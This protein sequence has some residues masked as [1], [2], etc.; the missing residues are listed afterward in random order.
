MLRVELEVEGE[1]CTLITLVPV[2]TFTLNLGR[3][4]YVLGWSS[5]HFTA[6]HL[7]TVSIRVESLNHCDKIDMETVLG[8]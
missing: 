7:N 2:T 4:G 5:G 8:K 3:V 1:S 6:L